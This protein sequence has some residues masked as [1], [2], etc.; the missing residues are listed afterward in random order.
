VGGSSA[1]RYPIHAQACRYSRVPLRQ[2]PAAPPYHLLTAKWGKEWYC[3]RFSGLCGRLCIMRQPLFS[4]KNEGSLSFPFT[5]FYSF[6]QLPATTAASSILATGHPEATAAAS[7][8][9][10]LV[11]PGPLLPPAPSSGY[12]GGGGRGGAG[13]R[14]RRAARRF[15]L[16]QD[17]EHGA[18]V[19]RPCSSSDGNGAAA[20][21]GPDGGSTLARAPP[22]PTPPRAPPKPQPPSPERRRRRQIDACSSCTGADASLISADTATFLSPLRERRRRRIPRP[23]ADAPPSSPATTSFPPP[24][25]G[26]ARST[27]ARRCAR[28]SA[29]PLQAFLLCTTET[30][31]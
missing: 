2:S 15:R 19:G 29:R 23:G 28:G 26:R 25:T 9:L 27:T 16:E 31:A 21:R 20:D 24:P 12:S 7:S 18:S 10:A 3:Y 13:V 11:C 4:P 5:I 14:R 6:C 8:I 30:S 17:L 22:T 1:L